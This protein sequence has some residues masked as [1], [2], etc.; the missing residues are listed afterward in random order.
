MWFAGQG[1]AA[2]V[3]LKNI[4]NSSNSNVSGD[5]SEVQYWEANKRS[6]A[7]PTQFQQGP[8]RKCLVGQKRQHPSLQLQPKHGNQ[9]VYITSLLKLT[10]PSAVGHESFK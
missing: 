7:N 6:S 5:P 3:L 8:C 2:R 4:Y 1:W 9:L 10:V